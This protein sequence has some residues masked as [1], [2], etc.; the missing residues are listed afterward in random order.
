MSVKQSK[1]H[2]NPQHYAVLSVAFI[3]TQLLMSKEEGDRY[4]Q[5]LK[6]YAKD[7]HGM[8]DCTVDLK[9]AGWGVEYIAVTLTRKREIPTNPI[10]FSELNVRSSPLFE[11]L[12]D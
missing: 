2:I 1:Y 4:I 5:D 12:L 10:D 3:D 7:K 6:K 11:S 8:T 9:P